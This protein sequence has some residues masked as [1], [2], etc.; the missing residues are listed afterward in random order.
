MS[1]E[2]ERDCPNSVMECLEQTELQ[3]LDD[4]ET[5]I[6]IH[7]ITT[8]NSASTFR[9]KGMFG[10]SNAPATFQGIMNHVFVIL[11]ITKWKYYLMHGRFIIRTDQQS[12]KHLLEQKVT[13]Y[14]Q[15]KAVAKLLGLDYKSKTPFV[16]P[17]HKPF[18]QQ[19]HE[20]KHG[21]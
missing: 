18:C 14:L 12:F 5:E 4:N 17:D 2:E 21:E 1:D 16:R 10:L 7:A 6:S 9:L 13:T 3:E 15:Q 20:N 19:E 11:A 8:P